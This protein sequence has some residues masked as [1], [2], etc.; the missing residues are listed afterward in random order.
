MG[1]SADTDKASSS[2][3]AQLLPAASAPAVPPDEAPA[4]RLPALSGPGLTTDRQRRSP[5]YQGSCFFCAAT[6][7]TTERLLGGGPRNVVLGCS[8]CD[9]P[10]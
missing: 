6:R 7:D 5:H 2:W 9:Y 10:G 1:D 3:Y 4:V 8:L